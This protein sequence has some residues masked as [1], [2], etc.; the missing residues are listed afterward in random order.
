MH[1]ERTALD[2]EQGAP[3]A[4]GGRRVREAGW[5]WRLRLLTARHRR[6]ITAACAAVSVAA[7]ITAL[8]PPGADG[9]LVLTARRDLPR[10]ADVRAADIAVTAFPAAVVPAGALR[11]PGT[12]PVARRLSGAMRRGE[13]FTDAAFT[14]PVGSIAAGGASPT[15][16]LVAAPVRIADSAVARLLHPGDRVDVLAAAS[17]EA[18]TDT[19]SPPL[20]DGASPA[21][22][23]ADPGGDD[24]ASDGDAPRPQGNLTDPDGDVAEPG[25]DSEPLGDR[26]AMAHVVA[27]GVEVIE[28]V[29]PGTSRNGFDT[30]DEGAL[31]MVRT[32]HGQA[33]AL[34]A[35]A[36]RFRLSVVINGGTP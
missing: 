4:R 18:A 14:A 30:G 26:S 28:I 2:Q 17:G 10:G 15:A 29:G 19:W 8:R 1:D 27:A 25:G 35:A 36:A 11:V 33:R 16:D 5:W 22:E 31:I 12:R 32:G 20:S 34:A 6:L 23:P 9:V 13:P 7:T 21:P 24:S 3:G